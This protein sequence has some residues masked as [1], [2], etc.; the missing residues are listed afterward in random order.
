MNKSAIVLELNS[1]Y[2]TLLTDEGEFLRIQ[3]YRLPNA[4]YVGQHVNLAGLRP[5]NYGRWVSLAAACLIFV[6]IVPV[7]APAPAHAWVTLD[8]SSSLE[9]LVDNKFHIIETRSLNAGGKDFLSEFCPVNSSFSTLYDSY[10]AWSD[11]A[12]DSTILVTYPAG[13]KTMQGFF[14]T[15]SDSTV[16]FAVDP[17]VRE[18]AE[19]LGLSSGRALLIAEAN[20]QGISIPL[21]S[22]R[23][24][25]PFTV[26]SS[27]GADVEKVLENTSNPE[28]QAEKIKE[29]PKPE[30]K[31]PDPND[32][33]ASPGKKDEQ[34]DK[35]KT[36]SD[37]D[38]DEEG[39]PD[40]TG[41][42]KAPPG[43]DKD[44][45]GIPDQT[46]KDK[47]PPGQDKDEEDI[48]DQ[49]DKDKT[50]PGLADKDKTPPGHS[51]SS[52]PLGILKKISSNSDT[53]SSWKEKRTG[54]PFK[55]N[56]NNNN[57]GNPGKGKGKSG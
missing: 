11:K 37:Q 46:D 48:P 49:A 20:N 33:A 3:S 41:K 28:T 7:L 24:D 13:N 36:P 8:G 54:P 4:R 9:V 51:N 45:K 56:D 42:D 21:D 40:Q 19:K 17:R 30:A 15:H 53:A 10:Q 1:R 31:V 47:T 5:R 44:E 25:N 22:I 57:N 39:I 14:S 55:T 27:A 12:G 18:E 16:A 32:Q 2:A 6:L 23:E 34:T 29:L 52:L 50:P 35:D 26:I 43:Q 38:K